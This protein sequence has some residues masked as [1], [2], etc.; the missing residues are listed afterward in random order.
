MKLEKAYSLDMEIVITAAEADHL[1]QQRAIRSKFSFKCPAPDCDAQVTCANLERPKAKRKLNPYYKVVSEHSDS[2]CINKDSQN[3]KGTQTL[4]N[5]GYSATDKYI[6]NVFRINLRPLN[7]TKPTDDKIDNDGVQEKN[8]HSCGRITD[9][10]I[11]RKRQHEK[12]ISS[13]VSAYLNG[14]NFDV[15]LPETGVIPLQELFIEIDGQQITE[16]DDDMR[17]YY[18]KAWINRS[19]NNNGFSIRFAN[20]LQYENLVV[21][22][23]FFINNK[24]IE[25]CSYK[26]FHESTLNILATNKPVNVYI[27]SAIG[28]YLHKSGKHIN[29]DLEGFEYFDYIK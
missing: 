9:E 27:M 16:F 15:Q 13:L 24:L 12:T 5:D 10:S 21:R 26:K 23:T 2:C 8:V 18:G 4:K 19:P 28:P 17:I 7:N 11:Q 3:K 1:F 22:P 14:E 20:N 25:Q 29:F 6:E